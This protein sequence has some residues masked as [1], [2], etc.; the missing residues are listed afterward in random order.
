MDDLPTQR[1][2]AEKNTVDVSN[3]HTTSV[4]PSV[5]LPVS[6]QAL[7]APESTT[8]NLLETGAKALQHLSPPNRICAHLNAFHAYARF[9]DRVSEANHYCAHVNDEVRQCLLYD[10][11]EAN[12]RLIGVEYMISERLFETLDPEERKLWHSHVFE[13]KSGMLVMPTPSGVPQSVW[14]VAEGKEMEQVVHLYGKVWQLWQTDRG[15]VL[16]LG[17]PELMGKFALVVLLMCGLADGVSSS[18]TVSFTSKDQ[19]DFDGLVGDRNRRFGTDSSHKANIRKSIAV[20]EVH[21]DADAVWADSK[22]STA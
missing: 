6:N 8:N 21:P 10:S 17:K 13:V 22:S 1:S 16:P 7:G 14:E 18:T 19:L 4:Q 12:A 20:P 9:P 5:D 15:D 3:P 2:S 11:P